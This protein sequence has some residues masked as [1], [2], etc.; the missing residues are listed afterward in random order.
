MDKSNKTVTFVSTMNYC[1]CTSRLCTLCE[2]N[3]DKNYKFAPTIQNSSLKNS[4]SGSIGH[5]W[6]KIFFLHSTPINWPSTA[7]CKISFRCLQH[8]LFD[9]AFSRAAF[10]MHARHLRT[11]QYA[12]SCLQDWK[13]RI[14]NKS[15][16]VTCFVLHDALHNMCSKNHMHL[17]LML[18]FMRT[19][20][21]Y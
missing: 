2:K 17:S 18:L 14:S 8:N 12:Q 20:C 6:W 19:V 5:L 9:I 11:K 3:I 15:S 7:T 21:N 13:Y 10:P 1:I 16:M 4:H